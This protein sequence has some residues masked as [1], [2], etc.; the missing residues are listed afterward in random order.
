MP[1][2]GAEIKLR[3]PAKVNLTL[4]VLGKRSDDYHE[5]RSLVQCLSLADE[6]T[7]RPTAEGITVSVHGEWAPVGRQNLCHAAATIFIEQV[8][9]PGGVEIQLIKHIPA[10]RGLGGGS[11]DAAATLLG[12]G[13]LVEEAP[14]GEELHQMAAELGSDVPLFLSGGAA[15]ISGR[16]EQVQNMITQWNNRAL[17]VAWPDLGVSTAEAYELL[18]RDDFTDGEITAAAQHALA[19]GRLDADRHLFN[20]FQRAVYSRWPQIAEV[21]EAMAQISGA[22][23]VLSGSGS[24]VFCILPDLAEA[25]Q[26]AAAVGHAGYQAFAARPV[27]YGARL[28]ES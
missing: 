10:G 16:G 25:E 1:E 4:E 21:Q 28:V 9:S 2:T 13:E 27:E 20:C 15:V 26:T 22:P 19:E 18:E 11:S 6:L 5:L 7:L 3:A 14:S 17:L 23:A 12:L 8:G 24:A